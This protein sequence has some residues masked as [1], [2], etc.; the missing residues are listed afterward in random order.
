MVRTPVTADDV[1]QAVWQ[2]A[3][4]LGGA[5]DRDWHVQAGT[6]EWTCWE[7]VEHVAD[8]LLFYAGQIAPRKP[9]QDRQVPFAY[10]AAREGG[11]NCSVFG[12]PEYGNAGL[13]EV[14]ETCGAFLSALVRTA[15]PDVRG[16][17]IFGVSDPEGFAAMGAVEVLVYAEVGD[18]PACDKVRRHSCFRKTGSPGRVRPSLQNRRHAEYQASAPRN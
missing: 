9:A 5:V 3:D 14:F 10:R 15:S 11:P 1:D 8:D 13:V 6:V 4:L 7:T 18:P 16:Y 17:H 2:A 12:D